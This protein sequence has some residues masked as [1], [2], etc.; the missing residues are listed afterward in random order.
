MMAPPPATP[1]SAC[2]PRSM[3]NGSRPA[4][5]SADGAGG[6]PV[7]REHGPAAVGDAEIELCSA[8]KAKAQ[9]CKHSEDETARDERDRGAGP[10]QHGTCGGK[11]LAGCG[12]GPEAGLVHAPEQHHA[13]GQQVEAA[14]PAHALRVTAT[15]RTRS[16]HRSRAR[17]RPGPAQV[18]KDPPRRAGRRRRQG[19][20]GESPVQFSARSAAGEPRTIHRSV[21]ARRPSVTALAAI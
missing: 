2:G 5:P 4:V 15:P 9:G 3:K 11:H 12:P 10:G 14:G 17:R 13:G 21:R 20:R 8:G 1:S 7:P 19:L 16:R 18:S 6:H